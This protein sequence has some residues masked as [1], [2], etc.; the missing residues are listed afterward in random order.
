MTLPLAY[1]YLDELFEDDW[2][3]RVCGWMLLPDGPFDAVD[4][5]IDGK[6]RIECATFEM[7]RLGAACPW[8]PNA[9]KGA[10]GVIGGLPVLGP[11][12]TLEGTFV[13]KRAGEDVAGLA[14]GY[15]RRP[16]K[17]VFPPAEVMQRATGNTSP[18]FWLVNGM[19][20]VNDVRRY[21][22]PHVR[23]DAI[24]DVFDWGC[25]AGRVTRHIIDRFPAARVRGADI[26]REAVRWAD[27]NLGGEFTTCGLAPPLPYDDG[28]F[29]LITA[30]SVFTHLRRADQA[31]WLDEMR[32]LLRPGGVL[33]ATTHGTFAGGWLFPDPTEFRRVFENDFYDGFGDDNLGHVASAEYYRATYQTI[34]Y[35]R[36]AWAA[37]FDVVDVVEGGLHNLQ[38]VWILRRPGPRSR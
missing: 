37:H 15:H 23:F 5:V 17:D 21:L 9:S 8:I 14:F 18:K 1:G 29:D 19:K 25:G 36:D 33:L 13:G 3:I 30:F 38:D 2:H 35:T 6:D 4:L 16:S 12:E 27:A 24:R 7:E 31:A 10:F 11:E 32:R 26:D 20:D 22:A 34:A 28:S